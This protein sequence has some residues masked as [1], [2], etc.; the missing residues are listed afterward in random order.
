LRAA[1]AP[2]GLRR[3][4][5]AV[6]VCCAVAWAAAALAGP[7]AFPQPVGYV[8]DFA[9]LL[10]PSARA[11]LD[12]KLAAYSRATGNE[13]AIAIFPDLGG[14]PID[15]FT[16]R[17]E[18]AWKVGRRGQ[19]NGVLLVVAVREREVRIEVGYGLEGRVTDAQAGEII[20]RDIAPS[21]RAGDY[22]GGV[23]TAVDALIALIGG[24]PGAASPPPPT[25]SGSDS[26]SWWWLA[27]LAWFGVLGVM[28]RLRGRRCPRCH[29]RLVASA[30]GGNTV[31]WSCPRCGYQEKTVRSTGPMFVPLVGGGG[32]WGSGGFGG[33]GGFGGFGGGGSGGGGAS[34]G[35]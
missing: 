19:D 4:A 25:G 29:A 10:D 33:G 31:V 9:N 28:A 27:P 34:G 8:N 3:P 32:G 30:G 12:A 2:A 35:W 23:N 20:R 5:A 7:A 16:A 22:A 24:A 13:I 11:S 17:L 15:D 1:W 6:L 18:E 26:G 21:F 14:A